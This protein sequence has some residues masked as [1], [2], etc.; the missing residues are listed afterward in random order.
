[1][2]PESSQNAEASVQAQQ[3]ILKSCVVSTH[4]LE[5]FRFH[6]FIGVFT[7]SGVDFTLF[8]RWFHGSF[9]L[10]VSEGFE[11]TFRRLLSTVKEPVENAAASRSF[12]KPP[13]N[14]QRS[15]T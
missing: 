4:N 1:M 10:Q 7:V 9:T 6:S 12:L 14:P 2:S 3:Q 15:C 11:L 5:G 13:Q 8:S